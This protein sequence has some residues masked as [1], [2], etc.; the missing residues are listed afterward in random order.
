MVLLL[1]DSEASLLARE[2][3]RRLMF[4]GEGVRYEGA[5][6]GFLVQMRRVF[7]LPCG[8]PLSAN[9]IDFPGELRRRSRASLAYARANHV[10]TLPAAR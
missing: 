1:G 4:D 5:P 8:G 3:V 10:A 2:T 6:S 7:S 9:V